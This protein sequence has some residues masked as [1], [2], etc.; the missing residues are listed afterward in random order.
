M[1]IRRNPLPVISNQFH[2]GMNP[3][4]KLRLRRF[5]ANFQSTV[6]AP[7]KYQAACISMSAPSAP[8][9]KEG[10]LLHLP[11]EQTNIQNYNLHN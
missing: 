3:L 10:L 9:Q 5:I 8:G 7:I 4:A 2:K 1:Y 6:S 11:P